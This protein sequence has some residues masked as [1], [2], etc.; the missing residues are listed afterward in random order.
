MARYKIPMAQD[1]VAATAQKAGEAAMQ[2]AINSSGPRFIKYTRTRRVA[3]RNQQSA[4]LWIVSPG[5]VLI[6][7]SADWALTDNAEARQIPMDDE[8]VRR[9]GMGHFEEDDR[10]YIWVCDPNDPDG[11]PI[12]RKNKK[13]VFTNA[14]AFFF[15]HGL[16]RKPGVKEKFDLLPADKEI[17]G[18]RALCIY[19]NKAV[20]TSTFKTS[21]KKKKIDSK[22]A[23]P[24]A[25]AT[26]EAKT[27]GK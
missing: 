16:V 4:N 1:Q 5:T 11:F 19:L 10:V 21:K 27:E 6:S 20:K 8:F 7:K 14:S 23:A 18:G 17:E 9:I 3:K 2:E 24:A 13:K 12:D 22:A 26:G 15:P 25:P